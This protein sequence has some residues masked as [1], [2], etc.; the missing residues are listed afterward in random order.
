MGKCPNQVW[1]THDRHAQTRSEQ[2][3]EAAL[4]VRARRR[5]RGDGTLSIGGLEWEAEQGFLAGKIVTIGRTLLET[6]SAPWVE[7]EGQKLVLRRVDPAHNGAT[8]R[9]NSAPRPAR[10][11]DVPFDPAGATLRA[12]IGRANDKEGT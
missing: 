1:A 4:V 10:G 12:A 3:L 2:Q 6:Q 5:I 11:I 8:N 9:R 7:Q